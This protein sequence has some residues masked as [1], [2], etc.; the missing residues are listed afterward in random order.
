MV[1][2]CLRIRSL[3]PHR[4]SNGAQLLTRQPPEGH[5]KD[6]QPQ[7]LSDSLLAAYGQAQNHRLMEDN[8]DS[9]TPQL[10][11]AIVSSAG[12]GNDAVQSSSAASDAS[13]R[14][15]ASGAASEIH[16]Q[17]MPG[18]ATTPKNSCAASPKPADGSHGSFLSC[19]HC[20]SDLV[21]RLQQTKS[22]QD[23]RS[24]QEE[25]LSASSPISPA[26]SIA[27]ADL[28][29][30]EHSAA[31]STPGTEMETAWASS[32][33]SS[34]GA[35][36][37][38]RHDHA[39]WLSTI[40][41]SESSEAAVSVQQ[42]PAQGEPTGGS[43]RGSTDEYLSML[44]GTYGSIPHSKL[45]AHPS[46]QE[47]GLD[48]PPAIYAHP[49]AEPEQGDR[50]PA[51]SVL[52]G[53]LATAELGTWLEILLTHHLQQRQMMRL[54]TA[55]QRLG[56][57]QRTE[58]SAADLSHQMADPSDGVTAQLVDCIMQMIS[59]G[60]VH[61]GQPESAEALASGAHEIGESPIAVH[62]DICGEEEEEPLPEQQVQ[63]FMSVSVILVWGNASLHERTTETGLQA[64]ARQHARS[65]CRQ[66]PI[67]RLPH[68][69]QRLLCRPDG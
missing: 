21:Q 39:T 34:A 63:F 56:Q 30:T 36:D 22:Q 9:A 58:G 27:P 59:S 26:L 43:R 61:P 46:K 38:S 15:A 17:A 53:S 11:A 6:S 10:E 48:H 54:Q 37:S 47:N 8:K 24:S 65:S 23:V 25:P 51:P 35:E 4:A 29:S 42:R 40:C 3:A 55:C 60:S 2:L 18:V 52:D 57:S 41:G 67:C 19:E 68:L 45:Q 66:C 33:S 31:A 12:A 62:L 1:R 64:H 44:A 7:Q 49:S 32:D 20:Q 50:P 5:Q 69:P 16:P 28:T 13:Q 14:A